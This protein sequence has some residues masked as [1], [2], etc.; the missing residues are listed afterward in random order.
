MKS[1]YRFTVIFILIINVILI[2]A[3][4]NA[5][6][7]DNKTVTKSEVVIKEVPK[8]IPVKNFSE[9]L[10]ELSL[11]AD[12]NKI[13]RF[14]KEILI[15]EKQDSTKGFPDDVVLFLGSSSIRKWYHLEESMLPHPVLNRGFGGSTMA[16]AIYFF[17]R[18]AEKYKPKTIV[19]YEGDNDLS[20]GKIKP[21]KFLE[22]FE[23]FEKVSRYYLP[24]TDIYFLS[25]K[26]SPARMKYWKNMSD[27]N[28]LVKKMTDKHEHLFYIDISTPML[29]KNGKPYADLFVGDRLHLSKKGYELWKRVIRN[30]LFDEILEKE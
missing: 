23:L 27:A 12:T 29:G 1:N 3:C 9:F 11:L 30:V 19:L 22:L 21:E 5:Q 2:T 15:F 7:T 13:H 25:V 17:P 14:E 28:L 18:I 26:P 20:V 8:E 16:E 24:E 10:D 4:S 6:N